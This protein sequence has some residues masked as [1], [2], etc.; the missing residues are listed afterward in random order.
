MMNGLNMVDWAKYKT[1]G[2]YSGLLIA[3]NLL[4]LIALL[5]QIVFSAGAFLNVGAGANAAVHG[6]AF[7][8][9]FFLAA[10]WI[11]LRKRV[12]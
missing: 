3:F 8:L 5:L 9:S 12:F 6:L 1:K 4:I 11:L 2:K 10:F 7:L